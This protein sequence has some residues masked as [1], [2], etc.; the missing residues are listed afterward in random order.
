MDRQ[1][2]SPVV[3]ICRSER[4]RTV[5]VTFFAFP[6]LICDLFCSLVQA[7]PDIAMDCIIHMSQNITPSQRA[8]LSHLLATMDSTS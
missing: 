4:I 8:K 7:N 5:C 3:F 1:T 6:P 2:E